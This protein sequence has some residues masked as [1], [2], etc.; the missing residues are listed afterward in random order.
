LPLPQAPERERERDRERER[1]RER[2]REREYI[3]PFDTCP[4]T[5][6]PLS[7]FNLQGTGGGQ[8]VPQSTLNVLKSTLQYK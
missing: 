6:S 3:S 2:E 4:A 5:T 7:L 8:N 1:G